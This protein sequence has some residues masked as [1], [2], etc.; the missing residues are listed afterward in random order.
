MFLRVNAVQGIN[1]V[2]KIEKNYQAD[3]WFCLYQLTPIS[4][5]DYFIQCTQNHRYNKL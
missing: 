1:P 5:L 4:V 2:E 3:N